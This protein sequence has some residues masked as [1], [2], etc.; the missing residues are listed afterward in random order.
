MLVQSISVTN[1][2]ANVTWSSVAGHKY[3]LQYAD[4]LPTA[5]W[6][7]VSPDIIAGGS[8][9]VGTNDASVAPQRFFRVYLVQ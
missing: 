1:G 4:N 6:N 3:R 7:S 9:V 8:T 5:S 2:T